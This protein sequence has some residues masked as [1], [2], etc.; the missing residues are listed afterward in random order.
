MIVPNTP[1]DH[2]VGNSRLFFGKKAIEC[3]GLIEKKK[4]FAGIVSLKEYRP[5]TNAGMLDGFLR[6]PFEFIIFQTFEFIGR[7]EAIASM[8]L[9]QNR[10]QQ[11]GDLAVSQ[12]AEITEALDIAMSGEIAFGKHAMGILCIE[13]G[14][15]TLENA[16]SMLMVEFSNIGINAIRENNLEPCYWGM[17]PGNSDYLVRKATIN[18]LNLAAFASFHNYPAGDR[19]G[20]FWGDAVTVFNTT[21]GTPFF[22][23][24]HVRDVG[25]TMIIGPTGAGKTVPDE[26]YVLS[27]YEVQPKDILF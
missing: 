8:Q 7:S 11:S 22:F 15:K 27:S 9:Q 12:I 23:N 4:R 1:I 5:Q 18:T 21:S 17:L 24:F 20:N 26:F 10:M 6:L 13:D 2:F 25:H 19:T 3:K 16:L 14:I